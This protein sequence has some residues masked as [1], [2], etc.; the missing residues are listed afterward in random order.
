MRFCSTRI[1]GSKNKGFS[2]DMEDYVH[3]MSHSQPHFSDFD[4]VQ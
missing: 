3:K 4:Y 1:Y 2:N